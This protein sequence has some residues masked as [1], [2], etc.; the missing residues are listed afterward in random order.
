MRAALLLAVSVMALPAG[1]SAAAPQPFG[2]AC[3]DANGVRFCPTS[4]DVARVKSFDGVPLDVDARA[5]R[6]RAAAAAA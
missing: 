3:T 1:A 2:H 6:V 5:C 4:S